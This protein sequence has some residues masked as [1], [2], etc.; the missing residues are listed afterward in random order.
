MKPMK[1][2]KTLSGKAVIPSAN[3]EAVSFLKNNGCQ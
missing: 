2:S 3:K 1:L